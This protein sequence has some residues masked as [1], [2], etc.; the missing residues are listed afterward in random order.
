M[1][2]MIQGFERA[3]VRWSVE[4][5]PG[6]YLTITILGALVFGAVALGF[7]AIAYVSL[8]QGPT[9]QSLIPAEV[10]CVPPSAILIAWVIYRIRWYRV[11][12]GIPKTKL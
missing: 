8:G 2:R 7:S 9:G 4:A 6:I 12:F 11:L 3:W 10:V 1:A 5:T